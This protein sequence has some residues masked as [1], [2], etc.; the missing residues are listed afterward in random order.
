MDRS[1]TGMTIIS[2]EFFHVY[3]RC[4][5]FFRF[6]I[7]LLM[8]SL[9]CQTHKAESSRHSF[10]VMCLLGLC[11]SCDGS[12]VRFFWA[13]FFTLFLMAS[14]TTPGL[15]FLFVCI[16]FDLEISFFRNPPH[17]FPNV[18]LMS[19]EHSSPYLH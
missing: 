6:R 3:L 2:I 17:V 19:I 18:F 8:H 1:E 9:C 13:S 4:Q 11:F 10:W 7:Y 16:P 14:C 15:V 12:L 5:L